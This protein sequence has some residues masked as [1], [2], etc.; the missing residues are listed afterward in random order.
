MLQSQ[1]ILQYFYKIL[2]SQRLI[3]FY[4][5]PPLISLFYLPIITY[6]IN[7]L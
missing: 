4:L 2:T 6:H 5:D 1:I 7:S 3:S